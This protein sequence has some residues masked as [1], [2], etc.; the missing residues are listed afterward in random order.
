MLRFISLVKVHAGT[1]VAAIVEAG[2]TMCAADESIVSG[3]VS[4]GLGLMAAYGAPE[5][6]Y[7]LV[8]DF[9][10]ESGMNTWAAG[11]AHAAFGAVVGEAVDSFMVTQF[12]LSDVS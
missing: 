5:A 11:P 9:A 12:E 4:A 7:A 6:S 1:D 3:Q 8:L 2:A 10:D